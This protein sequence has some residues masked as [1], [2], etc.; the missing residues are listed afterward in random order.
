[1]V[2]KNSS[3]FDNPMLMKTCIFIVIIIAILS[4]PL[5]ILFD[6]GNI[7]NDYNNLDKEPCQKI[8]I[9]DT[10]SQTRGMYGASTYYY[11]VINDNKIY[12]LVVGQNATK[13][14]KWKTIAK[15]QKYNL[16]IYKEYAEFCEDEIWQV[17]DINEII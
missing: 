5:L 6:F 15:G 10:F 11:I 8:I 13:I 2:N 17:R 16:K 9:N 4:L 12:E 14:Y 7:M 1:M 3:T